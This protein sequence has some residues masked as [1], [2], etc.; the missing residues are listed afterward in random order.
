MQEEGKN[1]EINEEAAE[2]IRNMWDEFS[3]T[4]S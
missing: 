4:Y 3:N 2:A 1:A